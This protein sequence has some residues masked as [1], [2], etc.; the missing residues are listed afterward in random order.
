MVVKELAPILPFTLIADLKLLGYH[1][2]IHSVRINFSR[3]LRLRS[4]VSHSPSF[5]QTYRLNLRRLLD[6]AAVIVVVD[7]GKLSFQRRDRYL[8]SLLC[9]LDSNLGFR[10]RFAFALE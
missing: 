1:R 7:L 3:C 4:A 6:V 5:D 2:L 10:F 8:S 9:A